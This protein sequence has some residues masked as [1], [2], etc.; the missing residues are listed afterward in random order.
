MPPASLAPPA[1]GL[2]VSA[3]ATSDAA[4]VAHGPPEPRDRR[5]YRWSLRLLALASLLL[6][7]GVALFALFKDAELVTASAL[8]TCLVALV[9]AL[10][11]VVGFIGG[12]RVGALKRR[13]LWLGVAAFVAN[14]GMSL[15]G[16]VTA[17]LSVST[18]S[19][20]RQLRRLGRVLLAPVEPGE[21]WLDPRALSPLA[22]EDDALRAPLAAQW[23]ANGRTEHA[24]VA[25]FSRLS[26]DLMALGAPASLVASAHADALDEVRHAELCFSLASAID[27]Q[28]RS[29]AA[30]PAAARAR[31]LPAV[32][33]LAL[34]VLAVDSLVDGALHEG[35]S[36]RV[37]AR[38][39]RSC[40][41]PTIRGLLKQIAVDE[42][43]HAAHGWDVVEFCLAEGGDPVAH[44]LRGALTKLPHSLRH[45]F[46]PAARTGGWE[47]YGI[48]GQELEQEEFAKARADIV[49]RLSRLIG[50]RVD[51]RERKEDSAR[52]ES[53]RS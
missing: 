47:R 25:A 1:P 13:S 26:L 42:G 12:V 8:L 27:G 19:R 36:A 14:T 16:A 44:A 29:P 34:A 21:G 4:R 50:A 6:V 39:S 20:G 53:S 7:L 32:R 11:A 3:S 31:T 46:D 38:L 43:R 51:M 41:E 35:V 15:V 45:D 28:K 22:L 49:R 18:F 5:A 9:G 24:S 23:R 52:A 10:L 37:V 2:V 33:A 48:P 40:A 17:L 30:F